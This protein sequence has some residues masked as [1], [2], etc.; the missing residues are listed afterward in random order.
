M[1]YRIGNDGVKKQGNKGLISNTAI[2][3]ATYPT[4]RI[5]T[6]S[7]ITDKTL[8]SLPFTQSLPRNPIHHQSSLR[9]NFLFC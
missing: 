4:N 3:H 7:H 6:L 5:I 1:V 2:L 8:V 9:E